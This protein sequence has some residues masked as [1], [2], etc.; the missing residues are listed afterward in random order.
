MIIWMKII[1]A[2]PIYPPEI[3]GPATYTKELVQRLHE[4]HEITV[5][6]LTNNESEMP[7]SKLIPIDKQG[8]LPIR[9]WKFFVAMYQQADKADV[10]YVQNAMA[11]GL[12]TVI[13]AKLRRKPVVLKFVGDEP[14]ERA[15]Q[16]KKTNK[17]LAEFLAKPDAGFKINLMRYV[18]GWVLRRCDIVTTPS[19]YLGELITESY[20]LKPDRVVTNYNAAE[21]TTTAPFETQRKPYQI[22]SNVRLVAWKGVDGIIKAVA[23]LKPKYPDMTFVIHGDGPEKE[24]LEELA[25]TE[26]VSDNVVFTGNVSRTETWHTR[27]ESAVYVLNSTY[28]GLPNTVLTSFAAGI[29]VI[30]TE[31]PGTDE[32]VYHEKSGLLV[33]AEDPEALAKAIA[34]IFEDETLSK[35]L[36]AGGTEILQSKFSWKS[37][38]KTL[39]SFF[40]TVV[41]K[42]VN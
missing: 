5:V 21:K 28:E 37:H 19:A 35:K 39:E 25:K 30:A 23:K 6:A 42:P 2:T 1:L 41:S 36:V 32:T 17:R 13:A 38:L 24:K 14:W 26:G 9:L 18:Q 33:P 7:G 22:M 31:I 8:T 29:P 34:R 15:S 20:G 40:E 16:H 3:G 27:G 11:A 12:P 10:L 4:K